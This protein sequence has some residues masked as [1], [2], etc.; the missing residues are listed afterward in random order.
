[1]STRLDILKGSLAK[2]EARFTRIIS[3][4]RDD[5]RSA[6]GQPLN[7]KRGGPAILRRWDRQHHAILRLKD[8]IEKTANALEREQY[9]VTGTASLY[10]EMPSYITSLID[11]GQIIQWRKHPRILFVAGVDKARIYF[12][13]NDKPISHKF[14][15]DIPDKAQ[16]AIFRDTFNAL[17]AA[18]KSAMASQIGASSASIEG[19][20]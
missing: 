20:K 16:Y 9:K 12:N 6:N 19:V 8:E 14:A 13:G 10:D 5:V 2:K 4:H 1:M 18:H 15:A 7:D 17:S 11:S 3:S